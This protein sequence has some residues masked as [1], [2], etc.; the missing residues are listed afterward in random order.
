MCRYLSA[1]DGIAR[2][3][4]VS[5]ESPRCGWPGWAQVALGMA[6][7]LAAASVTARGQGAG[8]ALD[9]DGVN[10]YVSVSHDPSLNLTGSYTIEMFLK[11]D[12]TFD[13]S[14]SDYQGVLDKGDYQVFLDP[15]DGKLRFV[16]PGVGAFSNRF[17]P[18]PDVTIFAMAVYNGEL[19][20]GG[21]FTTIA[22]QSCN[23]IARFDGYRWQPVGTGT[24]GP[25][26]SLA[27]YSYGGNS[28]LCVGGG[29]STAGGKTVSNIAAW[30]LG[31]WDNSLTTQ[32]GQGTNNIVYALLSPGA[33]Q[34]YVGGTFTTA[35][36]GPASRIAF[37][38]GASWSALG[39]GIQGGTN[40]TVYALAGTGPIYVGGSFDH[41]GGVAANN[42][43]SWSG[44]TWSSL[45]AGVNGVDGTVY[46][47]LRPATGN[48]LYVGGYFVYAGGLYARNLAMWSTS[49]SG[50]SAFPMQIS[51]TYRTVY[52]LCQWGTN[53]YVGGDFCCIGSDQ[54]S[55]IF[56]WDGSNWSMLG[57][58]LGGGYYAART[59][60]VYNPG[61]GD[62]L[63]VGGEF[64][65]AGGLPTQGLARWTGSIWD[66]TWGGTNDSVN[67]FA[68]YNSFLYA[69]G[70]FGVA[71][72]YSAQSVVRWDGTAWGTVGSGLN[73]YVFGL[74]TYGN[75][76]YATGSF[77]ASGG[78]PVSRI[79]KW[80][81]SQWSALS[82]GLDDLGWALAVYNNELYVGGSFAT[83]GS[84][85]CSRI[86]RWNGSTWHDLGA[87]V[88]STSTPAVYA[89]AVYG[90]ELYVGGRFTQAGGQ[91]AN[92]IAKW[93][94]STWTAVGSGTNNSVWALAAYNG[95]LYA[96]GEFTTAGGVSANHV[97]RWNGSTW[98]AAGSGLSGGPVPQVWDF[99][100]YNN[101]LYAGGSFTV[102]GGVYAPNIAKWNGAAWSAVADG[103]DDMVESLGVNGNELWLGG[104][105]HTAGSVLSEH[106]ATWVQ[107]VR[108]V[109][110]S[111]T[112]WPPKQ[113]HVAITHDGTNLRMYVNGVLENTA[114]TSGTTAETTG[115]PLWIGRSSGPPVDGG[116]G[117]FFDGQMDEFRIWTVARSQ[118]Q[119]RDYM[120]R[121]LTGTEAGLMAYYRF[122]EGTGAVT[123]DSSPNIN[124]GSL[125]GPT[126][127][128]SAAPL[129]D[130]AYWSTGGTSIALSS[131]YG[132]WF[133]I[134]AITG[135]PPFAALMRVDGP[136]NTTQV[137][138]GVYQVFDSHY[139]EVWIPDG[140]S[141]HYTA[142]YHYAGHP[143]IV[144]ENALVLGSRAN[145]AQSYWADTD[146]T[147]N[148]ST[149]TLTVPNQSG[150][151]Y[152]LGEAGYHLTIAV[153]PPGAG[154]T[155]SPPGTG[156]VQRIGS[157]VPV[158]AVPNP[159]YV[160]EYW[161]TSTGTP[162]TPD[163]DCASSAAVLMDM[164]KT[165]TA[166][167]AAGS[168]VDSSWLGGTP[169]GRDP[170]GCWNTADNW[171]PTLVPDNVTDMSFDVDIPSGGQ[172]TL[173]MS[174]TIDA[175]SLGNEA[176]V[177]VNAASGAAVRTLAVLNP[178]TIGDTGTFFAADGKRLLL[179]AP[180]IDQI[181][182][183]VLQAGWGGVIQI[184]GALVTG[185]YAVT[186]DSESRIELIGGAEFRNVTIQSH[187]GRTEAETVAVPDA[188]S[189]VLGGNIDDSGG[190]RVDA[191]TD[192]TVLAPG[193]TGVALTGFGRVALGDENL[194]WFGAFGRTIT[195][196]TAHRIEG[197]GVVW[198]H[199][200]N[201]GTVTANEPGK[202]LTI[203]SPGNK[204]NT[205]TMQ[206]TNAGI[207][208]LA[209]DI[210]GNGTFRADGG[211]IQTSS[212]KRGLSIT[213]TELIA[214]NKGAVQIIGDADL[215]MTTVTINHGGVVQGVGS[216]AATLTVNSI[217]LTADE[218]GGDEMLL[219]GTM[220]VNA[221]GPVSVD[222]GTCTPSRGCTPP[223]LKMS[224]SAVLTAA[225]LIAVQG[226]QIDTLG[227]STTDVAGALTLD[228]AATF[229]CSSVS[230]H[231]SATVGSLTI[232]NTGGT[233][234]AL[235]LDSHMSMH[236]LGDVTASGTRDGRGC[237]PPI[238][239][240]TNVGAL[241]ID[242]R[243]ILDG[244]VQVA[245]G[246]AYGLTLGGDLINHS[247]DPNLFGCSQLHLTGPGS[248]GGEHTVEVAGTDHGPFAIGLQ[249]NFALPYLDIAPGATV[250]FVDQFDNDPNAQGPCSEALYVSTFV[251]GGGASLELDNCRVYYWSLFADP[252]GPP[253][254][255]TIVGC[256]ALIRISNPDVDGDGD[257]DM[258]DFGLFVG[259][260]H[261][262]GP[263]SMD[264]A[265]DPAD[266]DREGDVDLADFALLQPAFTGE[267]LRP[268]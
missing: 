87:G 22:G 119:I 174:P 35:G 82:T 78:V 1:V 19:Y 103:V 259:C 75:A 94:G 69:G 52:A 255:I 187:P 191:A 32:F 139:F 27:V 144:D 76:L 58:G 267:I 12:G 151:Q 25:V 60:A 197:A 240:S 258:V 98:A 73:N 263:G 70:R 106:V 224:D 20:V 184:N 125:V 220:S 150:T 264:P 124:A 37:F 16:Q 157:T 140:N 193:P 202:I 138:P 44:T 213:G 260:L 205:G 241:Q 136:P 77:T 90:N 194:A 93:N 42:I 57:S 89:L 130:A 5:S 21:A 122:D 59:L 10:D 163:P 192:V 254:Q 253:A 158:Q 218:T 39:T 165:V 196:D 256:G 171:C 132:D 229:A 164:D 131:P 108:T 62:R 234:A 120:N 13:A 246:G 215:A 31:T 117:Q 112:S 152:I 249:S 226:G 84:A 159:G 41:A 43:A 143:D 169:C 11:P 123:D 121:K 145:A 214:T 206:A 154:T 162:V 190:I 74:A 242:G 86:A 181:A 219:N 204:N 262:P 175:L 265:C 227:Y 109:A 142:V 68:A 96:G 146:A 30:G 156:A 134:T 137:G 6:F 115:T 56:K 116:A 34:L 248:S 18:N 168:V 148:T 61:A 177:T 252:N 221:T 198:G 107:P 101:E 50:W 186:L 14:A 211:T 261:G 47:L 46:A 231:A 7:V 67:A 95:E 38:N 141:P 173:N 135:A 126:W 80:D 210:T 268:E 217:S 65:S 72:G 235:S 203:S 55:G 212:D 183:G 201:R 8:W 4:R 251:L 182:G 247:T 149:D 29:F 91:P 266:Q 15:N 244:Y 180:A 36:G 28:Y 48:V 49:G 147:R 179:D 232:A 88:T 153:S 53:L 127:V 238:L 100:V 209:D 105:F 2:R 64:E 81:G 239:R 189:G 114:S 40:P 63:Y 178:I 33:G 129:G 92:N 207:L 85:P 83:A 24:N 155:D 99:A 160:F 200:I 237:T 161:A 172:V 228:S 71:S 236:V 199:L 110:S 222:G 166:V 17:G 225:S 208:S 45:G 104:S 185:G 23:H 66:A 9:F 79:A 3:K 54:T 26:F 113:H 167:F 188:Q 216:S 223:I 128:T 243:L 176:L 97:A 230:S 245:I 257:V 118:P 51:Q 233:G 250:H 133:E 111:R 102:A 195:N 170:L